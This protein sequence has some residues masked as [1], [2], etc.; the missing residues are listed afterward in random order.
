MNNQSIASSSKA[1]PGKNLTVLSKE[2]FAS[3]CTL[4][5]VA[6]LT[7]LQNSFRPGKVFRDAVDANAPR[8]SEYYPHAAPS[9]PQIS[10]IAFDDSGDSCVTSGED[11]A[12]II[13]DAR[14]GT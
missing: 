1:P 6:L 3:P 4:P 10:S 8:V 13:W 12:F 2:V 9:R 14:K 7:R 5:R 11:E